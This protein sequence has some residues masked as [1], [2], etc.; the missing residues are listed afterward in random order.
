MQTATQIE[1]VLDHIFGIPLTL[2][3]PTPTVFLSFPSTCPFCR[4]GDL[5]DS[6]D[7]TGVTVQC[8]RCGTLVCRFDDVQTF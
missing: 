5:V 7:D 2:H 4:S 3:N 6:G 8:R 1:G